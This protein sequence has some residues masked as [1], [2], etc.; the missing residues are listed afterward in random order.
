MFDF[1]K[2]WLERRRQLKELHRSEALKLIAQSGQNAYYDAQRAAARSRFGGDW[3]GFTFWVKVS[4]EISMLSNCP[5]E[6]SVIADIA[7]QERLRAER[8][9]KA[10]Q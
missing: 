3:E 7:E 2:R 10:T 5:M 8:I 4:A 1:F 9:A 6:Y